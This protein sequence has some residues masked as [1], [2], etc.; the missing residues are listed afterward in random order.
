MV[1]PSRLPAPAPPDEGARPRT[2]QDRS[3]LPVFRGGR[4]SKYLVETSSRRWRGL[5]R[6]RVERK[7]A[8]LGDLDIGL[9]GK[10]LAE[11]GD[12]VE[13]DVISTTGLTVE[14][15]RLQYRRAEKLDIALL[16]KFTLQRSDHR[17]PGFHAAAWKLPAWDIG[18]PDEKDGI[19]PLVVHDGASPEGHRP[20][21]QEK[22]ME[23]PPAQARPKS[24][25]H[26]RRNRTNRIAI[27]RWQ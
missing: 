6:K 17:L 19:F 8:S 11:L 1:R 23:Q 27:T 18:M 13:P 15:D 3:D 14:M 2:P 16:G 25:A 21:Q 7:E 24:L 22:G 12:E 20:P 5:V 26:K 4:S 9:F 10:S